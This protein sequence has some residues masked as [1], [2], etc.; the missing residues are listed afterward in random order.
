MSNEEDLDELCAEV[1]TE[2]E[3]ETVEENVAEDNL[4][5]EESGER[6]LLNQSDENLNLEDPLEYQFS[7]GECGAQFV[8]NA[9][10]EK[11]ATMFHGHQTKI[12]STCNLRY[13]E[14]EDLAEHMKTEHGECYDCNT[15]GVKCKLCQRKDNISVQREGAKKRQMRE[16]DRM[17]ES[18]NKKLKVVE[19]GHTVMIPVPDVDKGK[20]DQNQL[21]A[22]IMAITESGLYQL[23]TR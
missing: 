7:C 23:G 16:A 13:P 14:V 8:E 12:C 21:P 10:L 11:H 17:I 15:G 3:Q 4:D 9:H 1:E 22:I 6:D 19:V 18:T 5:E 2:V 20:I